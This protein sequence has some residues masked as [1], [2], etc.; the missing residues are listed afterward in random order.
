MTQN[1]EVDEAAEHSHQAGKNSKREKTED[2]TS[3]YAPRSYRR[4]GSASVATTALGGMAYLADFAIGAGIG[5]NYGTINALIAIVLAA[6]LI[7]ITA[8]PLAYYSARY[9]LDLDLVI[10]ELGQALPGPGVDQDSV[11][12]SAGDQQS[13][14][15]D[16][17]RDLDPGPLTGNLHPVCQRRV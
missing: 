14:A 4:W 16:G 13:R 5:L 11:L 8:L 12:A 2:Y 3:R 17:R 10:T 7:F 9:N 6:G 15:G 1:V